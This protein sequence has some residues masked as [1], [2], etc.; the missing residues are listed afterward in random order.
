MEI[1]FRNLPK[2]YVF[3]FNSDCARHEQC[4]RWIVSNQYVTDDLTC[5]VVRPHVARLKA[6]PFYSKPEVQ[7]MAWGFT[8]LFAEV[9]AKD[10]PV[11]REQ[12]R[13]YLGGMGTYS[14]YK[15]GRRLLTPQQQKYIIS[16]FRKKGYT[17]GLEFDNYVT[18]YDLDH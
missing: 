10:G 5:Q 7:R 18:V 6:C 13:N 2:G 15:L 14:R 12:M 3:C 11:L 4:L 9:K 8:K 17:E 1:D 16:L